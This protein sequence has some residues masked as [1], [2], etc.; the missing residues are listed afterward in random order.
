MRITKNESF[1]RD[2]GCKIRAMRKEKGMTQKEV[3]DTLGCSAQNVSSIEKGRYVGTRNLV[4]LARLFG[5]PLDDL[6]KGD[7]DHA[8]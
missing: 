7:P 1:H 5:V 4:V 6:L 8:A 3:A 2:V